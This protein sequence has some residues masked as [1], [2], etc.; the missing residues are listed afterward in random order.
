MITRFPNTTEVF[1]GN[2]QENQKFEVF[3]LLLVIFF[4][5]A[6]DGDHYKSIA[7]LLFPGRSYGTVGPIPK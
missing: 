5:I 6:I 4:S 2:T 3:V 7:T 1:R